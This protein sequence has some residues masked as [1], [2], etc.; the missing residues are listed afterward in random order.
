MKPKV[1][2]QG[3]LFNTASR[4]GS[5]FHTVFSEAVLCLYKRTGVTFVNGFAVSLEFGP[6]RFKALQIAG[7]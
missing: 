6:S 4:A 2:I 1:N 3:V 7:G 5:L